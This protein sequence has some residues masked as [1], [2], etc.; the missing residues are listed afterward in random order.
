MPCRLLAVVL[1]VLGVGIARAEVVRIQVDR[2]EPFA[3][4]QS[5]GHA[6]PYEKLTGRL[7]LE[8]DPNDKAN[9]AVVDLKL[10][11]RNAQG[12]VEF[13]T[14]FCLLAPVQRDA[15]RR[16]LFF[17]V[18]NRGNKLCLG[19][20]N[21][22]ARNNDPANC[23]DAGN[24]FL[25]RQG[26]AVLWCAW[27]GD[28]LP[29]E[30]RM[31]MGLPVAR[32]GGK[33]ITGKIYSEICVDAKSFSQPLCWGGSD[34]YPT[35]TLDNASAT[36][37]MCAH[38]GAP[39]VEVPRD[40]WA[41]ARWENGNVVPD[42]KRVYV[43]EGFRP[44]WLYD[45]VYDGRDPRV[46][47][48]GLAAVRDVVSFFRH[49]DKDRQGTANPL[50]GAI[51][52]TVAFGISQ[53][54]RFIQHFLYQGF[55]T[56]EQGRMV[57]EGA[58]PVVGG[59]G[60]G[61]FNSRFAQ[62][63][64]YGS[65]HEEKFFPSDAFPFATTPQRDPVTGQEDDLLAG[66]RARGHIPKLFFIETSAEYWNRGGSLL[67]TDVEGRTDAA[68]DPHARI[69]YLA[70]AQHVV[71]AS[72]DR[73]IYQNQ[74]NILD[75]RPALRALLVAMDGWLTMGREPPASRYPRFADRSLV[76]L[77]EYRR[78]FPMIPGVRLPDALYVPLRLDLG[79]RW[80]T[81]G[82]SDFQP[83]K[84]GKPYPVLVPAVD[85][86]GNELPGIRLPDVAV[87]LA[88]HTGWNL[89]A[90]PAGAEGKLSR[91]IGSYIPFPRT[92]AERRQ[93]SD[94]RRAVLERYPTQQQYLERI[95]AA[96]RPLEQQG[97]LL[98]EDVTRILR[99]AA[100]RPLWDR[101]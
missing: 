4:A 34:P 66:A 77:D 38:R 29:G 100:G 81:Q 74:Q 69:Y 80:A 76:S 95:A 59:G 98:E 63:T 15:G 24:G 91:W 31:V 9:A 26:Y 71:V 42:P 37:T 88:T 55:N 97:L 16:L 54:A 10:A 19:A 5:F 94:P 96:A 73:G 39:A 22:A 14:D 89:R 86:D 48:L 51:R 99:A 60:K 44:G 85:A 84:V 62:A 35:A 61:L 21:D 72:A 56:D 57:F 53:S 70:S 20:F 45:L 2:R 13:W 30:G 28:V 11:P 1:T 79:P 3:G 75:H 49:A 33:P 52:T 78:T 93:S 6:G 36:L 67:H 25:M 18:N 40:Q 43:K 23:A 58:M 92:A 82:I 83:P 101:P 87:P 7:Y 27:N 65:Q 64:R 32:E 17:E 68:V 8:V 12:K 47:G 90:A 50:A 41:F 46:T